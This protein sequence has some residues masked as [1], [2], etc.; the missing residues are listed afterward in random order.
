MLV[1]LPVM[2]RRS[3]PK[4][5]RMKCYIDIESNFHPYT[6]WSKRHCFPISKI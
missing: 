3:D 2:Q 6:T 4:I 5:L 1:I